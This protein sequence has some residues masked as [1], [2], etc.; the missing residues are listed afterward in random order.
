VDKEL[1][2]E[3]HLLVRLLTVLAKEKSIDAKY[4]PAEQMAISKIIWENSRGNE[5]EHFRKSEKQIKTDK[6]HSEET[7]NKNKTDKPPR[8]KAR[9]VKSSKGVGKGDEPIQ[10]CTEEEIVK[11]SLV[12]KVEEKKM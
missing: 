9:R 1:I 8:K 11:E 10:K 2:K 7:N 12:G 4:L 5:D 6:K 3:E